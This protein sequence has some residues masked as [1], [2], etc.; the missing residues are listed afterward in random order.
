MNISKKNFKEYWPVVED[1]LRKK[2]K[3]L[4][5]SIKAVKKYVENI[6]LKSL[7]NLEQLIQFDQLDGYISTAQEEIKKTGIIIYDK[8]K[9]IYKKIIEFSKR[10]NEYGVGNYTFSGSCKYWYKRNE[11]WRKWWNKSKIC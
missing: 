7:E 8:A 3:N 5:S 1:Y 2:K 9:H 4:E 6:I 10:L 11:F